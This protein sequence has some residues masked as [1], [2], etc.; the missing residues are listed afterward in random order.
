MLQNGHNIVLIFSLAFMIYGF[1]CAILNILIALRS[2]QSLSLYT[3]KSV[4]KT[5]DE[6]VLVQTAVAV[7]AEGGRTPQEKERP[8][9]SAPTFVEL[10]QVK[11]THTIDE[12]TASL[13]KESV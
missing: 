1:S 7:F 6:G 8:A 13:D 12:K 4:D 9:F 2:I 10:S 11:S 5:S 3:S